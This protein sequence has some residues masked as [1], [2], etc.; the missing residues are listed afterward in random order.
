[1]ADLI[2]LQVSLEDAD[3]KLRQQIGEGKSFGRRE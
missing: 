2:S 3:E 1:V